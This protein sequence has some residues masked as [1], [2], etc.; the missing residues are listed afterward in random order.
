[1]YHSTEQL[2]AGAHSLSVT[3]PSNLGSG[4]YVLEVLAGKTQLFQKKLLK[5]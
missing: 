1:V 5:R 4:M 3:L 2:P